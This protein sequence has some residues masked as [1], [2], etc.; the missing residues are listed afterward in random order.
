M[1]FGALYA[2]FISRETVDCIACVCRVH[3]FGTQRAQA[4]FSKEPCMW[5]LLVDVVIKYIRFLLIDVLVD[6]VIY[7]NILP[8]CIY[9]YV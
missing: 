9:I 7:I 5:I 4:Y 3:I 6:V 1:L 2:L 8:V